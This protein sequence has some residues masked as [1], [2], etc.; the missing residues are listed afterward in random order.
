[1][2]ND[3]A[4]V[5]TLEAINKNIHVFCEKPPGINVDD[6][7]SVISIEKKK[8][9]LNFK[10]GFNHRYHDS[11]ETALEIIKSKKLGTIVNLRGVYG[12]SKIIPF[13]GGWRSKREL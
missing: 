1:M 7:K 3:I 2:T 5:V 6:I 13:S 10:Y 11:V 12:K 4:P 8:P 9:K